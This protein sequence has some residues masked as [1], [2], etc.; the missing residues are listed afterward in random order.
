MSCKQFTPPVYMLRLSGRDKQYC[1]YDT[2][3]V[4][5]Y[6]TMFELK[7]ALLRMQDSNIFEGYDDVVVHISRTEHLPPIYFNK[8]YLKD[9]LY[10]IQD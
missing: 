10:N 4:R 3:F 2:F 1:S 6:S 9:E 7:K 5:S 8:E